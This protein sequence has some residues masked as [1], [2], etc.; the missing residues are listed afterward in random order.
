MEP[1][2][3]VV[4]IDGEPDD[5]ALVSRAREY[6]DAKDCSVTLLQVVPEVTRAR[7]AGGVVILPWQIMQT[8]EAEAKYQLESLRARFL[9]GRAHPNTKLVRFGRVH[10]ELATVIDVGDVLAVLARSRR[11]SF[12]PWLTRDALLRRRLAVPVLF[13][14]RDDRLIWPARRYTLETNS[15]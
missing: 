7:A 10:E 9:R 8:M 3:L 2:T 13:L 1:R 5:A 15:G 14:D 12:L 4:L 11:I 6:A